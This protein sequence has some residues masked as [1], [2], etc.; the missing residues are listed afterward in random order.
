[1]CLDTIV[2]TVRNIAADTQQISLVLYS[3]E[4]RFAKNAI[5]AN[6]NLGTLSV[7]I[8]LIYSTAD[9]NLITDLCNYLVL[10]LKSDPDLAKYKVSVRNE[11]LSEKVSYFFLVMICEKLTN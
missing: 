5:L 4:D 7:P 11:I 6:T 2:R 10:N 9:E 1:M 8:Q 3:A